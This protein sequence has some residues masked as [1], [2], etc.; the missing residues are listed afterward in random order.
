MSI[1]VLF[2]PIHRGMVCVRGGTF[3]GRI[4]VCVRVGPWVAVHCVCQRWSFSGRSCGWVHDGEGV[5]L[6]STLF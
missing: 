3:G 4:M 5:G 2:K 1:E 6:V